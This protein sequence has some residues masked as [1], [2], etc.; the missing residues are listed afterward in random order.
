MKYKAKLTAMLLA[1][2]MMTTGVTSAMATEIEGDKTNSDTSIGTDV[3]VTPD[4]PEDTDQPDGIDKP[5]TP[6]GPIEKPNPVAP[7][8]KIPVP[9]GTKLKD[10]IG[11]STPETFKENTNVTIVF[12]V[13]HLGVGTNLVSNKANISFVEG[14]FGGFKPEDATVI[15]DPQTVGLDS[16]YEIRIKNLTAVAPADGKTPFIKV[17]VTEGDYEQD[18]TATFDG[19]KADGEGGGTTPTPPVDANAQRKIDRVYTI[20]TSQNLFLRNTHSKFDAT[21][22]SSSSD[23]SIRQTYMA[24]MTITIKNAALPAGIIESDIIPKNDDGSYNSHNL[25]SFLFTRDKYTTPTI[26]GGTDYNVSNVEVIQSTQGNLV[27]KF[28]GLKYNGN[29]ESL[30]FT[31]D[32]I[33]N[34]SI[35]EHFNGSITAEVTECIP[36]GSEPTQPDGDDDDGHGLDV[37]TPYVIVSNYG[38]GGGQVTAGETFQLSMTYYNTSSDVDISN[39]M[40]TLTMPEDFMLTSSSNTF[41]VKDLDQEESV[42]KTVQ[43]TAKGA[44]KAQS[45]NIGVSMKYQYIDDNA[46]TRRS[47]ETTENVSVPVVQVDRFELTGIEMDPEAFLGDE[48]LVTAN[49]VNKGRSEVFNI[50]AEIDGNVKNPGQIQNLGNIAS[51][52]TGTVDFYVMPLEAGTLTGNVIL[53]YEDTNMELK[54]TTIPYS[55]EVMDMSGGDMGGGGMFP[56]GDGM[57][58]E[59]DPTDG[60]VEPEAEKS[61]WPMVAIGVGVLVVV[62]VVV[63]KVLKKKREEKEDADM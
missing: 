41:Y 34:P 10:S 12:D 51:G 24:D 20:A 36:R 4:K 1:V 23:A 9:A 39:M 48:V 63:L 44:A 46:A 52:A 16:K 27:I 22:I 37:E 18:I 55:V 57:Y 8:N 49:F 6:I 29:G 2:M 26:T 43:V 31:V 17:K 61:I 56:G 32:T 58:P 5:T 14:D 11:K 3:I 40:I 38:Y 54:S 7:S 30:E 45:H 15:Q 60:M 62:L 59:G 35:T 50:S 47:A 19:Y 25:G 42:T 21:S 53:N 28:I 33:G 13:E